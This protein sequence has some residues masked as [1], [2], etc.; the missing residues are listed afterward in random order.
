M[1]RWAELSE[2]PSHDRHPHSGYE[3]QF[4]PFMAL[5]DPDR[6]AG[7]PQDNHAV[8]VSDIMRRMLKEDLLR[9]DS[10]PLFT[11]RRAYT[12][13]YELSQLEA[14]LYEEVTSYVTDEMNRA[15]RL[16]EGQGRRR[17]TVGFALTILQ[18]RLASSPVAILRSL[19]RRQERLM[20]RL[21]EARQGNQTRADPRAGNV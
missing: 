7:K 2:H 6:F 10:T 11:E 16:G 5:I 3:D 17:N 1:K 12:V 8:D 18:R 9:F 19:E 15:D 13:N 21:E 14:R 4:Q 20:T